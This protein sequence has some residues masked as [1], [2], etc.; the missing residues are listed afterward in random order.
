M[1][2][3][4]YPE[5]IDY[6]DMRD[7]NDSLQSIEKHLIYCEDDE[8]IPF[9]KGI[10]LFELLDNSHFVQ[11]RGFGH[12]KIISHHLISEYLLKHSMPKPNTL[13]IT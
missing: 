1:V 2:G 3:E 5:N 7:R 10:E 4:V 11:A 6:Y 9:A 8:I 12:Y 13:L